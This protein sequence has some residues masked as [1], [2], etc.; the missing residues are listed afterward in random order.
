MVFAPFLRQALRRLDVFV[1]GA[2]VAAA[3]QDDGCVS[4]PLKINPVTGP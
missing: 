4:P 2:L 1:L 3:Q